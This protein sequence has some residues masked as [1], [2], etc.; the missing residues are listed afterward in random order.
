M[1]LTEEDRAASDFAD[2]IAEELIGEM[3]DRT[4]EDFDIDHV[5][6]S[7]FIW[8]A[9]WLIEVGWSA[10]QLQSDIATHSAIH[11]SVGSMQ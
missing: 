11:N 5:A 8:L 7:L 10:E 4:P 1:T 9:H 2:G 6:Y 3:A